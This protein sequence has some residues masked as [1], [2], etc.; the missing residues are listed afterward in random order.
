MLHSNA[1]TLLIPLQLGETSTA[2]LAIE[3]SHLDNADTAA[4]VLLIEMRPDLSDAL[5][6]RWEKVYGLVLFSG[7][8]LADRRTRIVQKLR[9]IGRLDRAFFVEL[10]AGIGLTIFIQEMQPLM[11]GWS[12]AGDEVMDADGDWVWRVWTTADAGYYFITGETGAGEGLS[13]GAQM[14]ME[15]LFR[16][17]KPADTFVE[18][19]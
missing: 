3:G 15:A 7:D 18:F 19:A 10:A 1:L 2:D 16:E 5:L 11:P 12:G 14:Y 4:E 17:L 9:G 13:S 6:E 8:S